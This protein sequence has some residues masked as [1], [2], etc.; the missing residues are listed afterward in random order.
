MVILPDYG[1]AEILSSEFNTIQPAK[2]GPVWY[3]VWV[4]GKS[5]SIF[6]IWQNEAGAFLVDAP[7]QDWGVTQVKRVSGTE[8]DELEY[9]ANQQPVRLTWDKT[10]ENFIVKDLNA[11]PSAGALGAI[12][13][14]LFEMHDPTKAASQ[15]QSTLSSSD[16]NRLARSELSS[17]DDLKAHLEYLLGLCYELQGNQRQAVLTY[18]S[19]WYNHAQSPYAVLAQQK[20]ELIQKP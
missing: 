1:Q 11:A 8:G 18:W 19:L 14:T 4:N 5:L 17:T 2:D 3:A 20:L 13:Q 12:N 6:R 7:F 15:I 16:F 10:T 9:L